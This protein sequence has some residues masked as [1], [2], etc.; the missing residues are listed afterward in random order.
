MP[1]IFYTGYKATGHTNK[2]MEWMN[3]QN[4]S[5]N[6]PT[7]HVFIYQHWS[8]LILA[9]TSG[10]WDANSRR[11]KYLYQIAVIFAQDL[12][13][14]STNLPL[15]QLFKIQKNRHGHSGQCN[16]H[17]LYLMQWWINTHTWHSLQYC[18]QW[19]TDEWKLTIFPHFTTLN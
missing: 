3:R 8:K 9:P 10:L 11:T 4:E 17:T 19:M 1:E 2:W 7:A 12:D 15:I 5:L 6:S 16:Y 18:C 13:Y 14:C